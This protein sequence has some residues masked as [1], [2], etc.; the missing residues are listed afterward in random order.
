MR[1]LSFSGLVWRLRRAE[2]T[3]GKVAKQK[4]RGPLKKVFLLSMGKAKDRQSG[5]PQAAQ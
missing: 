5:A 2:V 1:R 4:E 3:W